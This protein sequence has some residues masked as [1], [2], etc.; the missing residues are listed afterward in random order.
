MR[1]IPILNSGQ[2]TPFVVGA[3]ENESDYDLLKRIDWN[4]RGKIGSPKIGTYTYRPGKKIYLFSS[5]S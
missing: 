1:I 4:E 3:A 2:T 5:I